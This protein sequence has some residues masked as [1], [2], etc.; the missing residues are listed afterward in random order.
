MKHIFLFMMVLFAVSVANAQTQGFICTGSNVNVRIGPGLKYK[1]AK[2][3]VS[4][5]ECQLSKGQL[6]KYLGKKQD[7][8]IYV[9]VS[10]SFTEYH[11]K[12]WVSSQYLKPVKLCP[13]CKGEGYT[14]VIGYMEGTKCKRCNMRGYL[15]SNFKRK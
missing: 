11:C 7:G 12:G 13:S 14:N 6:V 3:V 8:F 9:D 4:E 15:T 10:S 2:D 1:L 5:E